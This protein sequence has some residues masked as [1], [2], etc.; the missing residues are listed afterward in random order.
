MGVEILFFFM[1]SSLKNNVGYDGTYIESKLGDRKEG[2]IICT[3][4]LVIINVWTMNGHPRNGRWDAL[5]HL[6]SSV[7]T[8]KVKLTSKL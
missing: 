1:I 7:F 5:C 3:L 8:R 2:W 6:G 4:S